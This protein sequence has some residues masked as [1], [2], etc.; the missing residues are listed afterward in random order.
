MA[1]SVLTIS[2]LTILEVAIFIRLIVA[3]RYITAISILIFRSHVSEML[4]ILYNIIMLLPNHLIFVRHGESECNVVNEYGVRG[5]HSYFTDDFYERTNREWRLSQKGI[6]QSQACGTWIVRHVL[7]E[8]QDLES[9]FDIHLTSPYLRAMETAAYLGLPNARW[10]EDIRL[11]ERDWGDIE[12]MSIAQFES[13]YPH[14]AQKRRT[15]PLYWRPP[16]GE[17]LAQVLET[18]LGSLLHS[19]SESH[20]EKGT[21]SVCVSTHGEYMSVVRLLLEKLSYNEWLSAK[22][23]PGGKLEN[24]QVVYFTRL[25][26]LT[27]L[28]APTYSW[29]KSVCPWQTPDIAGEWTTIKSKDYGND[30]LLVLARETKPLDIPGKQGAVK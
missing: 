18:R 19:L 26:P 29:V 27:G 5:D 11:R 2:A 14:N 30:E 28:Q 15:N 6:E 4:N 17:S 25:D 20:T 7:S 22:K 23:A 16:G 1:S 9:G 10:T 21:E 8:N 24:G 13:E 12:S 3:A